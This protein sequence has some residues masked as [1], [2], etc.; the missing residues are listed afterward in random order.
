MERYLRSILHRIFKTKDCL[1]LNAASFEPFWQ[2]S[3]I[4]FDVSQ[5]L[6]ELNGLHFPNLRLLNI[7]DEVS[8]ASR[9]FSKP[10]EVNKSFYLFRKLI[11]YI[12]SFWESPESI[13]GGDTRANPEPRVELDPQPYRVFNEK[14]YLASQKL[15][16]FTAENSSVD[17][18][19]AQSNMYYSSVQIDNLEPEHEGLKILH[20][21]DIHF[22]EDRTVHNK[23]SNKFAKYLNPFCP[24]KETL[25]L[26][27]YLERSG[28]KV[29]IIALTGDVISGSPKDLS[30]EALA[31]L[32]LVFKNSGA[33]FIFYTKGNHDYYSEGNASAKIVVEK[34]K[35]LGV[36]DLTSRHF[37][38]Q[39]NG[40]KMHFIGMDD[41]SEGPAYPTG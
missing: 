26:A 22:S 35:A 5:V 20:L 18:I 37:E 11:T 34:L 10:Q 25:D 36:Q 24:I 7:V 19:N 3:G 17:K 39:I 33:K 15:K 32:E 13:S 41:Y 31:A 27:N 6:N 12:D 1:E 38:I 16:K 2:F 8:I 29:D 28:Q 30:H 4:S 23:L 9:T 14:T 21:T 40:K